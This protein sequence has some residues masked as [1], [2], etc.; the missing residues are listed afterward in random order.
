MAKVKRYKLKLSV[1]LIIRLFEYVRETGRT[2]VDIHNITENLTKLTEQC[3][4]LLTMDEYDQIITGVK[5]VE[6]T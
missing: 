1:P 2:D 6:P 4:H 5:V 3:D